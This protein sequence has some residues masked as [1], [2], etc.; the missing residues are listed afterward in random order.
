MASSIEASETMCPRSNLRAPD[1]CGLEELIPKWIQIYSE[2]CISLLD[3]VKAEI[4]SVLLRSFC[5]SLDSDYPR[6][7]WKQAVACSLLEL[8]CC[9]AGARALREDMQRVV[10]FS[11]DSAEHCTAHNQPEESCS[12]MSMYTRTIFVLQ[13]A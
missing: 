5:S 8:I 11:T 10:D 3:R 7:S 6:R 12:H 9:P 13:K 2:S 1:A 4:V